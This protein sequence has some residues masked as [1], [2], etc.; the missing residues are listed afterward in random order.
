MD[1]C[2]EK[3]VIG[4]YSGEKLCR[5][6]FNEY[7]EGKVLKTIRQFE[8]IGKEENIGVAVSGGKDSLAVLSILKKGMMYFNIPP[9]ISSLSKISIM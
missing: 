3:K 5:N 2:K 9:D 8:L 4:L 1:C 6:H 7:F